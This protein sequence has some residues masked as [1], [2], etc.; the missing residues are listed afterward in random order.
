MKILFVGF[1][2]KYI[3]PTNQLI[4]LMLKLF[5]DVVLYGPGFVSDE[6]LRSGLSVFAKK[7]G[8]FDFIATIT[9]LA[10]E[11]NPGDAENFYRRYS[12]IQWG[13]AS[14]RDFIID[15]SQHM[16]T[17]KTTKVT[18][19]MD[20]DTYNVKAELL[21]KLGQFSDYIVAW[22][23]GFCKKKS[24]LLYLDKEGA[25]KD[26]S[27]IGLW[28]D[29]CE[30]N[31]EKFINIGHFVGANEFDFC[32]T[33]IRLYD[34]SVAGQLY[35]TRNK[36]LRMLKRSKKLCVGTTSYRVFYSLM[37]KI[38]L[39][40]YSRLVPHTLYSILFKQ[41]LSRS[42][43]SMTDGSAY[44]AV[45]RKF[46][47]IPAAGALLLARPC[48]GFES[49]GFKDGES[50]IVLDEEDPVGQVLELLANPLRL[51]SIASKGQRM[52]WEN[53]SI[54]ARARQMEQSLIRILGGGFSGSTWRDGEFIFL[55]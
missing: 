18:F 43:I 24:E 42:K 49:M 11:T 27:A 14:I 9:Q 8:P 12:L 55:D 36:S 54:H 17:S 44:D 22:G 53:H 50:A 13:R 3:N 7:H 37:T 5:A 51:Q 21:Q 20:L 48:V 4:P 15:S 1:N 26:K 39:S 16:Q 31:N 52:L 6:V 2:A 28:F 41:V 19:V 33:S 10:V 23:K 40:P 30:Q 29:F 32:P 45:I 35:Y 25:F 46:M 38:G 34:V 47:E